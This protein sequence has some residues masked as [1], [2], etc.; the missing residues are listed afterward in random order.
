MCC[1]GCGCSW[2]CS[3][4]FG[5]CQLSL[6]KCGE[7]VSVFVHVHVFTLFLV[8]AFVVSLPSQK[9][10]GLRGSELA[11]QGFSKGPHRNRPKDTGPSQDSL[12]CSRP[13]PEVVLKGITSNLVC[14]CK[15]GR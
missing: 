6:S 3:F 13:S 1:G 12:S 14:L 10:L 15:L 9:D 11:N 4:V 8:L 5:V 2:P 7:K